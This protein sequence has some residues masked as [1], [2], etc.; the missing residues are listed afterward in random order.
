MGRRLETALSLVLTLSAVSVAAAV[1]K[2]ELGARKAQ[3]AARAPYFVD[4]WRNVLADAVPIANA[5][6]PVR[7]VEFADLECPFCARFHSAVL[8]DSLVT[9]ETDIEISFVH[10]AL[11]NHRFAHTAARAAE[12]AGQQGRSGDFVDA[13][14][15][16]QDSLGLKSW[17]EYARNAAVAD[18]GQFVE[19]IE[20]NQAFDR[21]DAGLRWAQ[22]LKLGGTPTVMVNGWVMPRPPSSKELIALARELKAG[23]APFGKR[24][25]T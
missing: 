23:R 17:W 24:E 3:P 1:I 2:R 10:F 11:P 20:G 16:N 8:H 22:E 25:G 18:S 13:V 21:I 9:A 12:C 14:Y 15:S 5:G 4:R 6:G 7:V 19:C